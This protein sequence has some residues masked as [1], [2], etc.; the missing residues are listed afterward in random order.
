MSLYGMDV[1]GAHWP[2]DGPHTPESVESAVVAVSELVRYLNRATLPDKGV[3]IEAPHGAGVIGSL[4]TAAHRQVQ[5]CRQLAARARTVATDPTVRHDLCG[6]DAERSRQMA[7]RSAMVSAA[8]LDDAAAA[9]VQLAAR[10]DVAHTGID[11]LSHSG[12]SGAGGD[13]A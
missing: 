7:A 1:V 9:L 5:L 4:A 13:L 8:A 6:D 12:A 3:L 10:L 2:M 11:L